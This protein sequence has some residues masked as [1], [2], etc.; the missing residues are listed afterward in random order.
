MRIEEN[1]AEFDIV[2]GLD[3]EIDIRGGEIVGLAGGDHGVDNAERFG[4]RDV[5]KGDSEN[6]N[7]SRGWMR[8]TLPGFVHCFTRQPGTFIVT[9]RKILS[10]GFG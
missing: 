6:R 10:S 5:V 2:C 4:G 8:K 7:R 9:K 3:E 1:A